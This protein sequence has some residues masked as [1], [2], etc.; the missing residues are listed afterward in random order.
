MSGGNVVPMPGIHFCEGCDGIARGCIDDV[1]LCDACA[2]LAAAPA[3][4]PV[5]TPARDAE[6][7]GAPLEE[8]VDRLLRGS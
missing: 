4:A 5:Q 2:Q 3:P 8:I 1:W 6:R 7:F